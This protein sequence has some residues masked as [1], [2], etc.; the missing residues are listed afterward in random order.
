MLI[1]E[2]V[3]ARGGFILG[4]GW[5]GAILVTSRCLVREMR[6]KDLETEITRGLT[7]QGFGIRAS[8]ELRTSASQARCPLDGTQSSSSI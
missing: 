3:D 4:G 1:S 6:G 2:G 8:D 5:R 7:S